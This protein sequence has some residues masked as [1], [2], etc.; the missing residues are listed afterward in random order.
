[1]ER[2]ARETALR[3][4][5]TL[6]ARGINDDHSDMQGSR[7]ACDCGSDA[8]YA[9][10]REKTV[11]TALGPMTLE[12]AWYH[13]EVCGAGFAPRD[14]AF[15]FDRTSLSPAVLRMVGF[16]ASEH[17]FEI[18]S[19][20]LHELAALCIDA[21]TVERQAEALGCEV[22]DDER[23]VIEPEPGTARTLYLGLDG[24][25]IAV[26]KSEV[27][28][29]R[30]K[31]A[32]GSAKTRE[33]KLALVWSAEQ[34]DRRTGLPVRD[35]GSVSSN[36]A[37]ESIASRD[38]DP[39]ASPFARRILRELERRCFDEAERQ[40]AI[41]DGAA[42]IWNFASEHLPEAVQIIDVFHAREHIFDTAGA[43]YGPGT[44]MAK[45][46]AEQRCEE[47]DQ[48]GGVDRVIAALKRHPAC[49][50]AAREAT[51]FHNNRR[52]MRYAWF[53][54]EGLC[55][56]SG[57]VE[58]AC[59]SLVGKRLKQGGMHW[60]VEGANA[61]LALRCAIESDRFDDFWERRAARRTG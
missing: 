56:S 41:G 8:R 5:G 49:E 59:K 58:G 61:I 39:E 44:D 15:G 28:G 55:V 1:M 21:K 29:R 6:V 19:R 53:R 14:R 7:L 18:S 27:E 48:P 33:V 17:S 52:R 12:R 40:V 42:W 16:A 4:A 60:T 2:E 34:R 47:L 9:G 51:Y 30:G 54:Q 24:T 26:R 13:C 37:I 23:T 10:R 57:V 32:D 45:A 46:W 11:T 43:I 38:T 25:G 3:V 31:Q 35:P 22:A 20:L 50:D 36:G